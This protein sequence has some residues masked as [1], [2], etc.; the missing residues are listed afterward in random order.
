MHPELKIFVTITRR[1]AL[2]H[3]AKVQ[4]LAIRF[5]FIAPH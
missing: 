5:R 3:M 4:V 2:Q 1:K